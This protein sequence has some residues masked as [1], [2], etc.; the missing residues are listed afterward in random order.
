METLVQIR[1]SLCWIGS[2]Q[3]KNPLLSIFKG[4]VINLDPR[5]HLS[6]G[7]KFLDILTVNVS[8]NK[9]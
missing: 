8:H 2:H 1:F 7:N 3:G 6:W 5:T 9:N 4:R